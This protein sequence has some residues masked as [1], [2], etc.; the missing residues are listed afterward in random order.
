MRLHEWVAIEKGYFHAGDSDHELDN[1]LVCHDGK[2][3]DLG[4]KI[5]A[6]QTFEAGRS[7]NVIAAHDREAM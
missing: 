7:C 3:H 6:Y 2:L 5:G 4:D 1:A